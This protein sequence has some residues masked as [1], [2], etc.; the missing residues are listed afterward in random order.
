MASKNGKALSFAEPLTD[1]KNTERFADNA[2]RNSLICTLTKDGGT[3]APKAVL[4]NAIHALRFCPEWL[5][6][7]A[8]NE[9]S[10]HATTQ[11]PA[12]WQTQD[13]VGANWT[14]YEDS[15]TCEW[16]QH[17]GIHV[18]SKVAAEAVQ[19]V[20]KENIFH[21]VRNYLQGL[22]WDGRQRIDDWLIR[23]FGA[24]DT[25]FVRAVSSRWLISAVARIFRPGCQADHTLLLEGEQGIRKSSGLR[26]LCGD[27]WFADHISELGGKDSRL[28]LSGKWII[29][30]AE[31][32][33]VRRTDLER[34]KAFLVARIDHFRVPYGRRSED[35]RR[36]CVFAATVNDQTPLTDQTGNR[37]FWPVRC[38][39]IDIEGLASVRDQLWAEAHAQ[40]RAD[41][42]WWLDTVKLNNA[43]T[44]EQE[45][46]F[47]SGV[48]DDVILS[49]LDDPNQRYDGQTP[50]TPFDSTRDE[51]TITDILIHAVGKP[52]DR[53]TQGDKNQVAR[54][55]VHGGWKR[56]QWRNGP[57]RGRWCYAREGTTASESVE[58]ETSGNQLEPVVEPV[59]KS[60]II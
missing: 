57:N 31:L 29:E 21:P 13:A 34:V 5:G 51:V 25:P 10:M 18:N 19:T 53:C 32:D 3:G 46:R 2:W 16:L 50:V 43:A 54:Y 7:L 36:S 1:G 47:E 52:L 49:W 40:Y 8:Y 24:E 48:W 44:E 26:T 14:D 55:L 4:A 30:M 23:Y 6:V 39:Q 35:V 38:G 20:A 58:P 9:F 15:R 41:R 17:E 33:K 11:K 27:D 45:K 12:L 56:R 22:N 59:R 42:V 60:L 28:D 37:R